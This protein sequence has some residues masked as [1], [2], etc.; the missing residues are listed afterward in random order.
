LQVPPQF[1][2]PDVHAIEHVPA[3]QTD[4]VSALLGQTWPQ[5]PQLLTSVLR[6]TQAEPQSVTP[7]AGSHDLAHWPLKQNAKLP[8]PVAEQTLPQAPQ[9]FISVFRLVGQPPVCWKEDPQL[10][11]PGWQVIEQN[12]PNEEKQVAEVVLGPVQSAAQLPQ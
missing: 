10:A 11:N 5:S 1:V 7:K 8:G 6:L 4:V 9:L 3:I 2:A 12:V